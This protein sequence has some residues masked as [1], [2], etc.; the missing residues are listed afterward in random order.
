MKPYGIVLA[1]FALFLSLAACS[2]D[3]CTVVLLPDS[4]GKIGQVHVSNQ[5]GSQILQEANM[6]TGIESAEKAPRSPEKMKERELRATFGKALAGMPSPP[7]HF[8]LYFKTGTT[9]LTDESRELLAKVIPT[10]EERN[11][12]D[13]SVVG[14]TDRVGSSQSN[15]RLGLK[16]AMMMRE[17]LISLG[18]A[19]QYIELTSHGEDNPLV[20]TA[21]N[22]PEAKNRRIEV[23][24]R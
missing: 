21:D 2:R 15:Y 16:R 4:E 24:V 5:G 22:I 17:T 23:V 10:I 19:P 6:A 11:S 3:R 1:G 13:V 12:T 7:I 20:K 8:T 18:I 9:E 14:H